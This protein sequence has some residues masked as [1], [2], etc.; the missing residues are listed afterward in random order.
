MLNKR[1]ERKSSD[2]AFDGCNGF[3][4]IM[5]YV[6]NDESVDIGKWLKT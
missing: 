3:N 4:Q 1:Q 5:N 2:T 6:A